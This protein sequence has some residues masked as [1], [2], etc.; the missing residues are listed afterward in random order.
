[1]KDVKCELYPWF[2]ENGEEYIHSGKE[3]NELEQQKIYGMYD[4]IY[5]IFSGDRKEAGNEI[6][7]DRI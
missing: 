7:L 5:P 1:M 3:S 6:S 4:Y 2:I